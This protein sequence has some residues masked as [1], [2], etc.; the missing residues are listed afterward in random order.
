MEEILVNIV[1]IKDEVRK[2][3]FEKFECCI[4]SKTFEYSIY[5]ERLKIEEINFFR[6][7]SRLVNDEEF[8]KLIKKYE[9]LNFLIS[10][11]INEEED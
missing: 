8:D 3:L 2:K 7:L 10:S 6:N 4:Y 9:Y 5:S 1:S 11:I